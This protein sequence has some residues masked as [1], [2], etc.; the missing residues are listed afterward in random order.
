MKLIYQLLFP[1]SV[2][3]LICYASV[4]DPLHATI[5]EFAAEGFTHVQC[6]CPRCLHDE[7][8]ADQLASTYLAGRA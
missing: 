2:S 1:P 7:A 6:Y 5:D 4:M 3:V 8:E